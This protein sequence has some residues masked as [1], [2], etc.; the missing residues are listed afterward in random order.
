MQNATTANAPTTTAWC[1]KT[2]KKAFLGSVSRDFAP[3]LLNRLSRKG[4]NIP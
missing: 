4:G 2:Q 3:F 1:G